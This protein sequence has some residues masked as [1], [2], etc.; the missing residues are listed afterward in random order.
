MT[1]KVVKGS[2]WT[3]AGQVLPLGV[4]L[5]ATPIVIRLLGAEGYGVMVLVLLIPGYLGFADFGMGMASTKFGSEA[6]ASGSRDKEARI[7][8]TAGLI[9]LLTSV[10]VAA[11]IFL[12][13]GTLIGWFN[14][15]E[16][17]LAEA[18]LALKLASIAFV[19]NFLCLVFNTPQLT[20]LRMD[21]NTLVN[22]GFR[23]LGA[24]AVPIVIYLGGGIAGAI[25]VLIAVSSLTLLGHIFVSGRLLRELFQTSIERAAVRPMLKFGAAL[26]IGGIAAALLAN[27]EKLVLTRVTSVETLAFYSAATTLATMIAMFSGSMTQSLFPVFSQLQSHENR[28]VLSALY[29]RGIRINLILLVPGI[30][31]LAIIAKPFFT[32]W[33]GEDFGRESPMPFYI[34]SFGLAFNVLA[35]FPYAAIMASGRSD[36]FAKIYWIE[37]VPYILLVAWL[38]PRF[39]ASGAAAAWSI[40]VIADSAVLFWLA[41]KVAGVSFTQRATQSFIS[42][43]AIMLV[44]LAAMLYFRELNFAVIIITLITT[45]IYALIVWKVVLEREE[46]TWITN[47]LNAYVTR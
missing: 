36:I 32:I 27:S 40:R 25:M 6:F 28:G 12:L 20:R 10:P 18:S 3:L 39:G 38:T 1:T 19:L 21:L 47:K 17:L 44:P 11:A 26:V 23:I 14:V 45:A 34:L 46:I 37:L 16:H 22:A 9:A 43:F 4:S 5:F 29:S 15:P 35:Y 2:L 8:R 41:K 31:A 13:S 24:I 33:G 42:A 7:V 30:L